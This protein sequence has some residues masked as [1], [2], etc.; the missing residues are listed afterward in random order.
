MVETILRQVNLLKELSEDIN[1][2]FRKTTFIKS[3][4]KSTFKKQKVNFK[5]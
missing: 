2:T 3:R 4:A 1:F 5:L